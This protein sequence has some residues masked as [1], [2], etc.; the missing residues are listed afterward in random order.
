[1][2]SQ[3]R[4]QR[5]DPR[6]SMESHEAKSENVV[7]FPYMTRDFWNSIAQRSTKVPVVKQSYLFGLIKTIA[8]LAI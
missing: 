2:S 7:W 8:V 4:C 6:R 5:L 1:M 3:E